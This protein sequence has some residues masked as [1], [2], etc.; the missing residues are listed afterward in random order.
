MIF[1]ISIR[2]GSGTK[3]VSEVLCGVQLETLKRDGSAGVFLNKPIVIGTYPC[4]PVYAYSEYVDKDE[5]YDN[6]SVT[7]HLLQ[8]DENKCCCV[9]QW[10]LIIQARMPPIVFRML[11]LMINRGSR[12]L[13][14]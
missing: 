3:I 2:D 1:L 14:Y 10:G 13:I 5:E 12:Y 7:V 6:W 9:H 11:L 4:A 8:L